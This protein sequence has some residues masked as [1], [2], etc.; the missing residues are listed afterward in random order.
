MIGSN[1]A[2][3]N[4]DYY[5]ANNYLLLMVNSE[6]TSVSWNLFDYVLETEIITEV[7]RKELQKLAM[8]RFR[9]L[10]SLTSYVV[11]RWCW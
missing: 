11:T 5:A 2:L 6:C 4:I 8:K 7:T 3:C 1:I 9:K 10:K